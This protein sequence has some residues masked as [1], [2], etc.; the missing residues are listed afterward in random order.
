MPKAKTCVNI[1]KI[2]RMEADNLIFL[3]SFF[4]LLINS[5]LLALSLSKDTNFPVADL[6]YLREL[7]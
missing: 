6:M 2:I 1:N 3:F 7:E 4:C 5:D